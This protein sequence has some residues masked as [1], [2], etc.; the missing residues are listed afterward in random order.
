MRLLTRIGK[1]IRSL[2]SPQK[3][4]RVDLWGNTCWVT[5]ARLS[6]PWEVVNL[7]RGVGFERPGKKR[8]M[9]VFRRKWIWSPWRPVLFQWGH[10]DY[11]WQAQYDWL[12]PSSTTPSKHDLSPSEKIDLGQ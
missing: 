3:Q 5:I 10:K 12:F 9:K 2:L 11:Y 1:G 7:L 8:K 4:Y 6:T